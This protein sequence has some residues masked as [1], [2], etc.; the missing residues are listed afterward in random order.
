MMLSWTQEF[1]D[2]GFKITQS[3]VKIFAPPILDNL[4]ETFSC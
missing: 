1:F 2:C 3:K 4:K